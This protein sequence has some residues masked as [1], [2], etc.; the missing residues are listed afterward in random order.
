MCA[1]TEKKEAALPEIDSSIHNGGMGEDEED[2]ARKWITELTEKNGNDACADCG[3]TSESTW[4][5]GAVPCKITNTL[6]L[7][8]Y[9]VCLL[10]KT[11]EN[12]STIV[13]VI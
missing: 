1:D 3:E 7:L 4:H 11:Y 13:T 2:G 6:Q 8:Q 12:R 9:T 5:E 10:E